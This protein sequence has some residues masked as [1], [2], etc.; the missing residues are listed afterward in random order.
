MYRNILL[1]VISD[2]LQRIQL[3]G[4]DEMH[5]TRDVG[6]GQFPCPLGDVTLPAPQ[7]AHQTHLVRV[8]GGFPTEARLIKSLVIGDYSTLPSPFRGWGMGL[9]IPPNLPLIT[10]NQGV[11]SLD[12]SSLGD[13]QESFY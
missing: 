10:F 3:S 9:K 4:K 6:R 1:T 5:G 11:A 7:G 8:F 2:L 13:F 12:T